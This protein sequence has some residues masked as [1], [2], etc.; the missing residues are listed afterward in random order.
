MNILCTV[1]RHQVIPNFINLEIALRTYDRSALVCGAPAWRYA[2]HAIHSADKW[3]IN[4]FVFDEP[5]FQS[6]GMDNPDNP[7]G[8]VLSDSELL[9]YLARVRDKTLAY[10]DSLDDEM[11]CSCPENCPYTRMELV[12]RQFR[13]IS[14]HTGMLNGLTVEK[15][16][17]FPLYVGTDC[18]DALKNGYYEQ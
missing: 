3:F 11:L 14:F 18:T 6:D 4:P 16:G 2:Y 10:I 13:H 9:D 12:L 8:V 17:K 15:T 1:I 7:C 5:E